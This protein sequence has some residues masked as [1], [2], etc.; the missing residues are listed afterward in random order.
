LVSILA[1]PDITHVTWNSLA[2]SGVLVFII[3][4][5]RR[6]GVRSRDVEREHELGG[7]M[8]SDNIKE[9]IL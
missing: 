7:I 9:G 8:D 2:S 4:H 3:Y 1:T 5:G 6:H